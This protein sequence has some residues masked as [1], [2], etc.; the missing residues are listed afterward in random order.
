MA[1]EK[2]TV[3]IDGDKK[4]IIER[5]GWITTGVGVTALIIAGVSV[6]EIGKGT[7]LID[8]AITAIGVVIAFIAS[9]WKK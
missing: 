6:E 4:K 5:V 2:E 7:A 3:K 8:G 9:K 1:E